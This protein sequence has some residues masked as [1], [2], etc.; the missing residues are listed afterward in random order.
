MYL[1]PLVSY[2]EIATGGILVSHESCEASSLFIFHWKRL[3]S[4]AKSFWNSIY[5]PLCGKVGGRDRQW[6]PWDGLSSQAQ[7]LC[8]RLCSSKWWKPLR[9]E[10]FKQQSSKVVN[11]QDFVWLGWLSELNQWTQAQAR[12]GSCCTSGHKESKVSFGWEMVLW[13]GSCKTECCSALKDIKPCMAFFSFGSIS[14]REN[15]F[16]G[17]VFR[18]KILEL[19]GLSP[20]FRE[21]LEI[22]WYSIRDHR[23]EQRLWRQASCC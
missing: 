2:S 21:D 1:L 9:G 6:A 18:G 7:P 23:N 12:A 8:H 13:R 17:A 5:W 16:T 10:T 19:P 11:N 14:R 22:H 20:Y 15:T 4:W 3:G